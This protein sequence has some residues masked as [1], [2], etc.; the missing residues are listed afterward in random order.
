LFELVEDIAEMEDDG[1]VKIEREILRYMLFFS[2]RC[3]TFR[4]RQ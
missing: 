1:A 4:G 3:Y 2:S